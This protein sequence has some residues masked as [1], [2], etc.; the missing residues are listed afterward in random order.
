MLKIHQIRV[1]I[2]ETLDAEHIARRL[3]ARP[4]DILSYEIERESLDA[5]RDDLH[6][7]YT[8]YA[9][10]RGEERYL[11]LKDV[12]QEE[13]ERY[14]LPAVLRVGERPVVIGFG[15][16]GMF[17]ALIL[18]ECGLCPIVLERGCAVE[19]RSRQVE[20]FFRSGIL[21]PESNVQFGEGGAGT[22]SDGKLTTRIKNIRISRVLEEFIEA[23]ADPAIAYEHRAHL[24]T[25]A[26]R[27]IVSGIRRKI[28]SLGGEIRFSERAE[29]LILENGRIA[30][31]KTRSG[32]FRSRCVILA[33]GHSAADTYRTLLAQGVRME[34]KDFA[35]GVRV[36][37]PQSLIDR[38]T[39]G[40]WAG[41]PSLGAASYQ[42]TAKTSCGRGV[43]SFCMCPGGVV[44]PAS[45]EEGG[46]AVNGMS[47]RAR[48]G[49]NANSAIL[50]QIPKTDFDH[51]HPLDGFA[52]QKQLEQAAYRA[53]FAA[54]AQNIRDFLER[55]V[56]EPVLATSYPRGIVMEDMHALF[57]PT[58]AGALAEGMRAFD[59]KIPGFVQSGLMVGMES[60]SSSPVRLPRRRDGQAEGM[61]GLFPCGEGAGYAGGI[62]SSAVDG[63]RQA[64]NVI[65][66]MNAADL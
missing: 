30:G 6:Y 59:R 27:G 32:I 9:R 43:Y 8:V 7:S 61:D 60:R 37:H 62:I 57:S 44:I 28:L 10:V 51:G 53:H 42:L 36:E 49:R 17:A 5:R 64:E 20:E 18:A 25:D 31:V 38:C 52:F 16:A 22:F 35:A 26:L 65:A 55:T 34:Q 1:N 47:Y 29:E 48:D 19:E 39:Y 15:P 23:G 54:P 46:L 24:G 66:V 58:A 63:I 13:K 4:S 45:A 14:A 50:V 3:K 12:T 21:N 11:R 33:A 2:G 40:R 41:H 56:S